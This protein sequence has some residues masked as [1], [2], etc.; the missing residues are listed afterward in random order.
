MSK[1][2]VAGRHLVGFAMIAAISWQPAANGQER[3]REAA[4]TLEEARTKALQANPELQAGTAHARA[5]DGALRQSRALPNPDLSFEAEDFGGNLPAE[6]LSQRTLSISERVEWFG[7]RSAR[8]EAARLERDVAALDLERRRLDIRQEVDRRFALLLVSQQ[9]LGIARENAA[10]A[11]EVRATV[12]TLVSAGEASPIEETRALGDEALAEIERDGASRDVTLAARSLAQLW[13]EPSG[14][15]LHAE[16]H[17]ASSAAVPDRGTALA[18]I[19]RLPDLARWDAETARLAAAETQ[20]RRQAL[21]DFTLSAGTRSFVG[22]G[23][24]T[25]VAG[26]SL[27]IPLLTT[28]SGARSEATARLEKARAEK[29]AEEVRL[30][31][32]YLTS[33]EGLLHASRE[34]RLLDERVLPNARQVYDALN[35][36]YRRGK[37]RLLDLLEARRALATARLRLVDALSRLN[38]ALADLSRLTGDGLPSETRGTR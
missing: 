24:R 11:S 18:D 17:L 15:A 5:L 12:S 14:S 35:E 26:L 20:A 1:S 3:S 34:V 16:G 25:W 30:R 31:A 2:N 33:E 19:A 9:R 22:T 37:F 38:L 28:Y 27:P 23:Q 4:I 8:V 6:A 32:A 10:T 21:P 13:G 7:K 29:R 36:G